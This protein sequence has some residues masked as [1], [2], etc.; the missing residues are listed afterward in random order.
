MGKIGRVLG[1][2]LSWIVIALMVVLT[3]VVVVAVIYRKAGNSLSWYDEVASIL[4]VW[5]TYYGAALAALRRSHIG[6][7]DVLRGLPPAARKVAVVLAEGLVVF[8]FGLLAW[9]GWQVLVVLEGM[10][11]VSLT[12]V[13]VQ[14][15]Q[16]VIPIGAVLFIVAELLSL[17]GYW[18]DV[19]A[20]RS[21]EHAVMSHGASPDGQGGR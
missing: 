18:R 4:L 12:W 16:S 8:F 9:A 7:D 17:P 10:N 19:M 2:L 3:V 14:F 21:T 20:G 1:G 11:L 15:T 5:I 6:F 13:P